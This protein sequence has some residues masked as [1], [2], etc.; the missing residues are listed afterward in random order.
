MESDDEHIRERIRD[1]LQ[2]QILEQGGA[3]G[4]KKAKKATKTTKAKKTKPDNVW[5]DFAKNYRKNH[6]NRTYT[7]KELSNIY[8]GRK[9]KKKVAIGKKVAKNNPYIQCLQRLH[10]VKPCREEA[11]K[12]NAKGSGYY[13]Y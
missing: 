8:H 6:P 13:L 7:L 9:N 11:A 5:V 3:I 2:A 4:R 1:I 10:Q 12:R